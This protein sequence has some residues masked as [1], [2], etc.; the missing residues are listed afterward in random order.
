MLYNKKVSMGKN[1]QF[2]Q[3]T[4]SIRCETRL[5]INAD[6]P[7]ESWFITLKEYQEDVI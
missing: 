6:R 4:M 1:M 2:G 5:A 7:T 3:R